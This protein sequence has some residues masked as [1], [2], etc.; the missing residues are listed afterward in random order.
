M[1]GRRI[2]WHR[3]SLHSRAYQRTVKSKGEARTYIYIVSL[4]A[5]FWISR[6]VRDIQKTA[7]RETTGTVRDVKFDQL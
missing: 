2:E 3:I 4:A 6:K 7:V 1:V 5:V